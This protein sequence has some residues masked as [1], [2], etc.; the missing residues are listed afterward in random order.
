MT[1]T[2]LAGG[3]DRAT[4]AGNWLLFIALVPMSACLFDCGTTNPPGMQSNDGG[5]SDGEGGLRDGGAADHMGSD[6][7]AVSSDVGVS[8]DGGVSSDVAVASD[9]G[10]T[11][12]CPTDWT[13]YGCTFPDGGTAL[14]CHNPALGCAS[15]NVCG[16]GCDSIVF[17]RCEDA[18]VSRTDAGCI[19]PPPTNG[20]NTCLCE[21]TT[22]IC[23]TTQCPPAPQDAATDAAPRVMCGLVTCGPGEWCDTGA[24]SPTCRCG[25]VNGSCTSGE[26]CCINPFSGCGPAHC[27]EHCA[28]TCNF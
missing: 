6:D 12:C 18:S 22:W 2:V 14:A 26:I 1:L 23:G 15:S 7:G 5:G 16:L 27:N 24:S 3:A 20:C 8:S 28:A 25:P 13:M 11:T 21:G 10:V 9:A 4:R 19:G 17:G